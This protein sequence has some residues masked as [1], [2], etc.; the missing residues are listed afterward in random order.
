MRERNRTGM[1]TGEGSV[2]IANNKRK[3]TVQ[4]ANV[5]LSPL[6]P[7]FTQTAVLSPEFAPCSK[8]DPKAVIR[9]EKER[10][11]VRGGGEEDVEVEE[12]KRRLL[13]RVEGGI[14]TAVEA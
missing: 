11:V 9:W 5:L 2:V 4:T 3:K 1:K 6:L 13:G 10:E 12:E 14:G 8:L 7:P